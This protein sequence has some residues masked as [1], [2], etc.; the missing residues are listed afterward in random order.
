MM[1]PAEFPQ[2]N[3]TFGPP[4]D[5]AESQVRTIPAYVGRVKDGSCDGAQMVVTAWFPDALDI[6]RLQQGHPIYLTFLGGLP[7][8]V[9]T[10]SFEEATSIR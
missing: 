9:P 8:H 6:V 3:T 7:P 2:C 10:T 4:S 5:M 1:T